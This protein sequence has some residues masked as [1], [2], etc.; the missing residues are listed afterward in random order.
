MGTGP[1]FTPSKK[2]QI[3]SFSFFY[4]LFLFLFLLYFYTGLDAPR[5]LFY[6]DS[7]LKFLD[8]RIGFVPTSEKLDYFEKLTIMIILKL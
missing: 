4:F 1:F 3:F 2:M 7:C 5:R 6:T 8:T